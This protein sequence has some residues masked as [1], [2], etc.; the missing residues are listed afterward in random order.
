MKMIASVLGWMAPGVGGAINP[1]VLLVLAAVLAATFGA[2]MTAG[3]TINGWRLGVDLAKQET[4]T[5]VAQT[6]A[7]ACGQQMTAQNTAVAAV[8][9]LGLRIQGDTKATLQAIESGAVS[10]RQQLGGLRGLLAKPPP[11][12]PDGSPAGCG[13]AWRDIEAKRVQP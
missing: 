9:A 7:K 3:W 10:Q 8:E 1:M 4:V 11:T 12:N 5:V 2:G 13:A 6:E